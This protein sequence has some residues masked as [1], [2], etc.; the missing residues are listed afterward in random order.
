MSGGWFLAVGVIVAG[1][2]MF[3]GFAI[4]DS[5]RERRPGAQRWGSTRT[6]LIAGV[7]VAA[8]SA[9]LALA[10]SRHSSPAVLLLLMPV[11]LAIRVLMGR[12]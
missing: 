2:L 10:I 6:R 7:V 8:A 5:T 12:R 4:H 3:L 11:L 9:A 1:A